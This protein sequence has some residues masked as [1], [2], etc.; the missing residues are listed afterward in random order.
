MVSNE[1]R[2]AVVFLSNSFVLTKREKQ[3]NSDKRNVG[4]RLQINFVL[5]NKT[6]ITA[7]DRICNGNNLFVYNNS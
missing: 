1:G 5:E 4:Y 3:R 6:K 2:T 7:N